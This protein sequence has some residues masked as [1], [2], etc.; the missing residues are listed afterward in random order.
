M[1][2]V[3]AR[4]RCGILVAGLWSASGVGLAHADD[5]AVGLAH[6]AA[7]R[8]AEA[9]APELA[10][11]RARAGVAAAGVGVAKIF[12]NPIGTV[13]STTDGPRFFSNLTVPLP[14]TRRGSAI[15]AAESSSAAAASELPL[16]RLDARLGAAN[17]W[18]DLWLAERNLDVARENEQ[19]AA[20]VLAAADQRF[21]E[22]SAPRLDAARAKAEHARARAEVLARAELVGDSSAALAYWLGRDPTVA[23]HVDGAPPDTQAL[24]PMS[25]LVARLDSHP[26]FARAAARARLASAMVS[27]QKD[28]AWPA[29]GVQVGATLG[30]RQAPVNNYSAG[31]VFDV[32]V[33]NW[34]RPAI[35]QA[36]SGVVQVTAESN[37]AAARLR[38]SLVSA[39][40]TLKAAVARADAAEKE[41]LPASQIAADLTA[42]AYQTGAIDLS[43]LLVA[44]KTLA[45]A[46]QAAFDAVAQRGRALAALEHALGG[47]L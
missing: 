31:L 17:A 1:H 8:N 39:Y 9:I 26:L 23:L 7:V 20:K 46:K 45:D 47:A 43:A 32:P 22:G 3:I 13:G 40:A 35:T 16:L 25:A 37:A 12:S 2:R 27:V 42:D 34:N 4:V 44:E 18:C 11:G 29:F 24:P 36:E 14:I 33:F 30:D 38:S 41:V 28:Q 10:A 21:R 19:R 5:T 6:G 15:R